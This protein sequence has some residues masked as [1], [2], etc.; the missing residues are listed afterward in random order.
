MERVTECVF[1]LWTWNLYYLDFTLSR[2]LGLSSTRLYPKQ[3]FSNDRILQK[4]N[5]CAALPW[6]R[7]RSR[8]T[9]KIIGTL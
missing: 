3:T 4:V 6:I 8:P 1:V 7:H 2:H 9:G 5:R